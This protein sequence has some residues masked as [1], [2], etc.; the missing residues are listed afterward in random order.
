[1]SQTLSGLEVKE[2]SPA[3]AMPI[4][5]AVGASPPGVVGGVVVGVVLLV[6][7]YVL[8]TSDL[9]AQIDGLPP[10]AGLLL[11]AALGVYAA[12]RIVRTVWAATR[13]REVRIGEGEVACTIRSLGGR[14]DWREPLSAYDGV[15]WKRFA[16]KDPE[17]RQSDDSRRR[18]RYRH[19]IELV[20]PDPAKTVPLFS[21][22]T[23]RVNPLDVL[24]LVG[25]AVVKNGGSV[26]RDGLKAEAERLA[27]EANAGDPRARWEDFARRLDLPAIDARDGAELKRDAADLDKSIGELAAEGKVSRDWDD[28]PPPPSL[29]VETLGDPADPETQTLR[30]LF[31]ATTM[32]VWFYLLFVA[33]G[34]F[35]LGTAVVQLAMGPLIGG[36][37]FAGAGAGLWYLERRNPRRLRL[38]RSTLTFEHPNVASRGFTLALDRIESLH[39]RHRGGAK[40]G[41]KSLPIMGRELVISSDEGEHAIGGGLPDAALIWLRDYL[42]AALANA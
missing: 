11:A 7:A 40:A 23:G 20:H 8:A 4:T 19:V 9:A 22:T 34:V 14:E 42:R 12:F 5:L 24:G 38:T 1:M 18:T 36:V 41:G 3:G 2:T 33:V 10:A 32:P 6:F 37:V 31:H 16:L 35:L 30:V 28:S 29:E 15:R 13:R 27:R 25:K 21:R 17:S 39:L 26:D